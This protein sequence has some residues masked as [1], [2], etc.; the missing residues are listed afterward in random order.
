[1]KILAVGLLVVT[2]LATIG[3]S[4]VAAADGWVKPPK[5]H[6][7]IRVGTFKAEV[8]TAYHAADGLPHDDVRCIAVLP[9]GEVYAG[10]AQ[11]LAR[12]AEGRW[13]P[14]E[15]LGGQPIEAVT[16][17]GDGVLLAATGAIH[18]VHGD[19]VLQ[20]GRYD[21][22]NVNALAVGA[23]VY[24]GS[25]RGLFRWSRADLGKPSGQL[26]RILSAGAHLFV[27]EEELNT[28]LGEDMRVNQ[29]AVGP[30]GEIA[31]AAQSGLFLRN[32]SGQWEALMPQQDGRQW[33][34]SDVRGVAF[35]ARS[36]LWC[37]SPQGAPCLDDTWQLYTGY[38]GLPYDDFTTAAPGEGG[39][40]WF[41][42]RL[43]AIRCDGNH[44]AYR[45]GRRWLPGD[46]V[47]AIAVGANGDAWFATAN[48]VGCIERRPMTFAEKAKFFEDEI[49]RYHRRTPYGYVDGVHLPKAGDRSEWVQRD[50]DNDGLWTAMYGAGEC[51]AYAATRSPAAKQ[52]AKVAFEALRY[53]GVVTQGGE[54]PAPRGFVA[55]T[56]LPTS[57][58]D[59]NE[60]RVER[61]RRAKATDDAYWKVIDPRWPKSE[62][63]QWYWKSDTSS[64]ELDGH[65]FFYATYYDLVADTEEEKARVREHVAALTDHLIAH[66]FNLVDWDG[67]PTRW[68]R[69]SP[70]ELNH[71]PAWWM[72]RGLNSLS[73][74]SYL[75]VAEHMT[76]D[77]KYGDAA[78]TLVEQ[79]GY[80]LNVMCPKAQNGPGSGNQSDDEMAFMGYYNLL[81]YETDPKLRQIYALSLY[82]YWLMEEA[83]LNP[84]FNFICA[85][86]ITGDT[87]TDPWGTQDLTPKADWLEASID[88]LKQY[89]LDR[90]NWGLKNSHR[91]DILFLSPYARED[92]ALGKGYRRNGKV[93][94]I[95]ERCV[96]HWNHDPWQLDHGGQGNGLADGASFL[97]PYYMGL[98]HTFILGEQ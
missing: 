98:Y 56:I 31:V 8:R 45:Q 78:R 58:P 64:D 23:T 26:K 61:D 13:R 79:H 53:L 97:L 63:G 68:A 18:L 43:G 84:L 1:M 41:G 80:A 49:D 28:L 48:G 60:G 54:H 10:T 39:V 91:K 21:F 88:T 32:P 75:K 20:V 72:E 86:S 82:N 16:T 29:I 50:S 17:F 19:E 66:N 37:A 22:G 36:R 11:G 87:F 95:D 57:G 2:F 83:E 67:K 27:P 33:A 35:D 52:R 73:I 55:R 46:D 92:G 3:L 76:G 25:D 51:F 40:I 6:K 85:A 81:K 42:T 38:D 89:P 9:R 71:D 65:Y 4:K 70:E 44:W 47:R 15:A 69:F 77:R 62:D 30:E 24:A 7:G 14:V 94:P 34:L 12:F 90:I 5:G 59:P 93:L 74:L 96:E